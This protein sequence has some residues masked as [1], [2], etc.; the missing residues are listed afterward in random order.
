[1]SHTLQ[2]EF[3]FSAI[4]GQEA[5][6]LALRLNAI[7]PAVGGVL[8]QGERGN[9]KTTTARAFAQV[10]APIAVREGCQHGCDPDNPHPFCEVCGDRSSRIEW[11]PAPL[12]ELPLGATEDRMIGHLRVE[13]ML[14][15]GRQEFYP[16]LL[17][18]AHRGVL[19]VDE[20]NLL[21]DYLVDILLDTAASGWARV[22]RDGFS[23]RYPARF[24]LVGSMNPEEGELRPQLLDRFGL[25]VHI[26]TPQ[27]PSER[28]QI[29]KRRHAFHADRSSFW[30]EWEPVEDEERRSLIEARQRLPGVELGPDM[31]QYIVELT[32][33]AGVEGLR[34]DI[35]LSEA[36]RAYAAW[37]GA[38]VVGYEH[39][40]AVAPMV[41][42]HRATRD[43]DPPP[44]PPDGSDRGQEPSDP[45]D[46][47]DKAPGTEGANHQSS[48]DHDQ[49]I[50][51]E[52]QSMPFIPKAVRSLGDKNEKALHTS[53]RGTGR[54]QG[55]RGRLGAAVGLGEH[56]RLG[57]TRWVVQWGETLARGQ[58][59]RIPVNPLTLRLATHRTPMRP[60][61]LVLLDSSA[62]M[63]GYR[64][65]SRTKGLVLDVVQE[66]YR[67]RGHVAVLAFR[68]QRA[69][70]VISP[71]NKRD[72]IHQA[73]DTLP[74]GGD[75]PFVQGLQLAERML[76]QWSR[77]AGYN[78][79]LWIV[80][81][82]RFKLSDNDQLKIQKL[83]RRMRA[84]NV[85]MTVVDA[86]W[87]IVRL[88]RATQVAELLKAQTLS[89]NAIGG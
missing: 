51:S 21:D 41:L 28:S 47:Y 81:D 36:S 24:V 89:V 60:L 46:Q 35:I 69:E 18:H 44:P 83:G 68:R 61:E 74:T 29:V 77:R 48:S 3:P 27:D 32:I 58:R 40:L 20:I 86:E 43:Y 56:L 5:F 11:R 38:Q 19:Y 17:A 6:K 10:L 54:R 7:S 33:R 23:L 59:P 66:A 71:T 39:V 45:A 64:R 1:M 8:A 55:E 63:A 75:T 26:T 52:R 30:A 62:S 25:M 13:T 73:V 65:M 88:Q 9:A 22:E 72:R 87:G 16:G 76:Q 70:V 42:A 85:R 82:G 80:T 67:R 14:A 34:A 37:Q 15:E 49:T 53:S 50:A 31:L 12:K 4:V 84:K 78:T 57:R 79:R 2:T